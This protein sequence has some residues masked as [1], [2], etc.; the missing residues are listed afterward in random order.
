MVVLLVLQKLRHLWLEI[1]LHHHQQT[2]S[3]LSQ[4]VLRQMFVLI[5]VLGLQVRREA[6]EDPVVVR[7]SV[8]GNPWCFE[9]V[10]KVCGSSSISR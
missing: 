8:G 6:P 9:P 10:L 3:F 1:A 4:L 2:G 7:G 5:L